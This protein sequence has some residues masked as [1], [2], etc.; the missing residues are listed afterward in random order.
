MPSDQRIQ[1]ELD[2]NAVG[3]GKSSYFYLIIAFTSVYAFEVRFS[4]DVHGVVDRWQLTKSAL[5]SA[6]ESLPG[7]FRSQPTAPADHGE[8]GRRSYFTHVPKQDLV[9][10][11]N[12]L[13]STDLSNA[14]HV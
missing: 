8:D 6:P 7:K 11:G 13:E 14:V 1:R 9:S 3:T 12:C 4:N 5:E 2:G 10:L